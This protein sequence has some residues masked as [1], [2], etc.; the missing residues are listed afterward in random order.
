MSRRSGRSSGSTSG[1]G[2][3]APLV[4]DSCRQHL[5]TPRGSWLLCAVPLRER[6]LLRADGRNRRRRV[7]GE[8]HDRRDARRRNRQGR[9]ARG[10]PGARG[11]RVRGRLRRR[12]TS[13]GSFWIREGNPLP[14]RTIELLAEHK[15]ALFGAITSKPKDTAARRARPRAARQGLRLLLADRRPAPALRPRHLRSGPASPSRATRSTSSAASADGGFE[16]PRVN[17]VIF[18]QNTEGLY[19]GVEWTNPP[20]QVWQ[21]LD[22]PPEVQGLPRRPPRGPGRLD[23]HLHPR[24]V[25]PDLRGGLRVRRPPRLHQRDGLREAQR[26]PRDLGHDARRGPQGPRSATPTSSSGTPTSTPR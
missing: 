16:E 12:P 17:A 2:R 10:A 1:P 24:Q 22:T 3:S 20:D 19:A 6:R 25:P 4:F 7:D 18:R 8:T 26:H 14:E 23:P 5:A 13:A 15:V 21:A 11:G 9:A